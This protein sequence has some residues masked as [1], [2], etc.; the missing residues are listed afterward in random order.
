MR[1]QLIRHFKTCT[2][3]IYLHKD[4]AHV[5]LIVH[6]PVSPHALALSI[7]DTACVP[8]HGHACAKQ[9]VGKSQSCMVISLHE[10]MMLFVCRTLHH[11]GVVVQGLV[12]LQSLRDHSVGNAKMLEE[13][14]QKEAT[15]RCGRKQASRTRRQ[16]RIHTIRALRPTPPSPHSS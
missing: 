14:L 15:A 8:A 5:G 10:L 1:V 7:P 16:Y 4:C 12:V 3:D 9:Y 13:N 6:A 2:T 11:S